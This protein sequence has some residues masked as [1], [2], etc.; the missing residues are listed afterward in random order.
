MSGD[1]LFAKLLSRYIYDEYGEVVTYEDILSLTKPIS[2]EHENLVN[3][4]ID[5]LRELEKKVTI[6][7]KALSPNGIY[8]TCKQWLKRFG[9]FVSIDEHREDYIDNNPEAYKVAIWDHMGLISGPGTKKEKIDLTVDYA[10]HFRNKC[11]LTGIF[12]QQMN[13]NSKSMDRKTNGYE[14]YQLDDFKDTS[15]TTDA[16]EVVIALYFPHREKIAKCEGYP[17]QN[18]LK[19]RFRLAQILK[20]RYGKSDVNKGLAFY[21]E[22]G[23]FKELPKP[24]EITDYEP[25]LSLTIQEDI[26]TL[27]DKELEDNNMFIF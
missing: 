1:I 2:K 18:T 3:K 15:G 22:I 24:E 12:I 11:S 14:L 21:G 13:R 27:L 5:W 8:A 26:E 17:I 9:E 10:I 20:N 25:Y 23:M 19:K 7:D 4:S 16:S 6:Y